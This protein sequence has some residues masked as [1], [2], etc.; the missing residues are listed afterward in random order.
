[1]AESYA[2]AGVWRGD[3]GG[4][5]A[6]L[7]ALAGAY[8]PRVVPVFGR[9]FGGEGEV[10]GDGL[11]EVVGD[12]PDEPSVEQVAFSH[13]VGG[14]PLHPAVR[15][16]YLLGFGCPASLGCIECDLVG[17]VL[18][19][20]SGQGL[21][22]GVVEVFGEGLAVLPAGDENSGWSRLAGGHVRLPGV[23]VLVEFERLAVHA[24]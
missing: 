22:D 4:V 23:V 2:S 6:Q 5:A 10:L 13:R 11:A 16:G 3:A 21:V 1:M 9:P 12:F 19:V 14:G 24:G 15:V 20:V 8:A 7:A 18:L 17:G